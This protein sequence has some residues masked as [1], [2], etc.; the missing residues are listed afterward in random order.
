MIH[1]RCAQL[2][3]GQD[4]LDFSGLQQVRNPGFSPLFLAARQGH[5]EVCQ[6]L[7]AKGADANGE[8]ENGF[9]P[10]LEACAKGN[11]HIVKFFTENGAD[12]EFAYSEDG[13]TG[14]MYASR[15]GKANVVRFLLSQ[16]ARTDRTDAKGF[17]ALN[18]A[19]ENEHEEI[20]VIFLSMHDESA[21]N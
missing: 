1:P 13:T 15:E 16:G 14:L 11:L 19:F 12:I 6:A 5:L 9:S 18:E 7:V 17:T 21:R 4:D 2:E 20:V 10:W 8:S 3:T